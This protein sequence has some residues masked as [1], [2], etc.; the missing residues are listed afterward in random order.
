MKIIVMGPQGSGKTTQA[1]QVAEEFG[2]PL[3]DAGDLVRKFAEGNTPEAKAV[4]E[5]ILSGD[6]IE[7]E[8]AARLV[9][10]NIENSGQNGF[11]L[12]GYP[13]SMEQCKIYFP[14][15]DRVVYIS[16]P[17]EICIDRLLKRGRFDDTNESITRRLE[18]YHQLTEPMLSYFR[19]KGILFEINGN[20]EIPEVHQGIMD[21][22]NDKD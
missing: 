21:I 17:D 12:D 5:K 9:K 10:E 13:R 3:I 20:R 7:N 6:L 11:V 4:K 16:L 22:L 2:L 19:E 1:S 18:L 8:V 15:V 14:E